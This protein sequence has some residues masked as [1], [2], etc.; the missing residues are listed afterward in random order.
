MKDLQPFLRN[1]LA[2][3]GFSFLIVG[4]LLAWEGYENAQGRRGPVSANRI[5]AY[6][7]FAGLCWT[8]GLIGTRLR[9]RP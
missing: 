3:L 7:V 4:T 9:H 5:A 6:F 1:W 8:L 2:R